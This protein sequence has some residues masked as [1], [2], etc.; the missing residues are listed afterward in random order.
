VLTR[1]DGLDTFSSVQGQGEPVLLLHGWG[2]SSQSLAGVQEMLADARRAVALDLPGF[3]WSE[4]PPTAW[5]TAEYARHVVGFMDALGIA[6][7]ALLG[8]SFGGR[9]AIRMAVEH[10]PRVSRL[11]LVASAGIRRPHGARYQVRVRTVKLVRGLFGLPVWGRLGPRLIARLTERV[12]SRDYRAAGAM[13][14]TLVKLVNEDLA[15]MLSAIQAPTLILWGDRD[16]E[17]PRSAMDLMAG[18]IPGA[19]MVVFPG[20][21]HFPFQDAPD[22][23]SRELRAFMAEGA[24][25]T[26]G[27]QR[28]QRECR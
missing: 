10:A 13:R 26:E 3:G 28:A 22:A 17:V 23:F 12:G 2:A 20:A 8:H 4:R 1:I 6:R 11:V 27:A 15:P 7:A 18:A 21:G 9:V 16:Q 25:G 5:G 19:R 24:E 14:P